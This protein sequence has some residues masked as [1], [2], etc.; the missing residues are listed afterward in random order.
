MAE[1]WR[2][3]RRYTYAA[4]DA[5]QNHPVV[6]DVNAELKRIS[7]QWPDLEGEWLYA[8]SD[9]IVMLNQEV[10]CLDHGKVERLVF[11]LPNPRPG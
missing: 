2:D 4:I 10:H 5:L 3:Q 1:S 11:L 9:C 7:P 6:A 8:Y